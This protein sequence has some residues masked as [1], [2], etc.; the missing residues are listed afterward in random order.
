[1]WVGGVCVRAQLRHLC[2]WAGRPQPE[3]SQVP[4]LA[5]GGGGV[6]CFLYGRRQQA[7][8]SR[9]ESPKDPALEGL[10]RLLG[11]SILGELYMSHDQK[12]DLR[13]SWGRWFVGPPKRKT[14][15]AMN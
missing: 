2:N 14:P 4:G 15:R 8:Q 10:L 13:L 6:G 5:G 11:P 9:D 1:M 12:F 7:R 3:Q